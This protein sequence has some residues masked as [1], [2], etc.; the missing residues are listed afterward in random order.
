MDM[1]YGAKLA[2]IFTA[3]PRTII[4]IAPK[5][6]PLTHRSD[7][8]QLADSETNPEAQH[9]KRKRNPTKAAKTTRGKV[10]LKHLLLD[11]TCFQKYR[12]YTTSNAPRVIADSA[13]R[14]KT[15]NT[16]YAFQPNTICWNRRFNS[17]ALAVVSKASLETG[18]PSVIRLD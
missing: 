2:G 8:D 16:K 9:R 15:A 10:Y 3:P 4:N 12:Q 18:L 6:A 7:P 14:R 11:R 13:H 17:L 5:A 1:E